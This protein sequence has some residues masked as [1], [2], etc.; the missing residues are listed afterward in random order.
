MLRESI[1][2]RLK[3]LRLEGMRSAYDETFAVG[4]KRGDTAEKLLLTLLEAE[5]TER[6]A[7]SMRYRLGQARFPIQKELEYFDFTVAQV[8]EARI[9][10][11]HDGDFTESRTNVIFVGGSGTGKTHLSIALG[12]ELLRQKKKVRF[13]G[14]VDLVNL[15]EQEKLSGK[16]GRTSEQLC[17]FDCVILDELGYLPFSKNGGQFLFH[18]LS[19][20]YETTSV[21]V[22]TNLSFGE[23]SHVF[24]DGKMTTALLD[25]LTHHCEIVETGNNSYRLQQQQKRNRKGDDNFTKEP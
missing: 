20:L 9:R 12:M 11:L 5:A 3:D 24:H 6:S 7:R 13:C 18:T 21:I 10:R 25:R 17:R 2:N 15:L 14:A 22:T 1:L 23:W 8:E 4:H 19:K 16:G